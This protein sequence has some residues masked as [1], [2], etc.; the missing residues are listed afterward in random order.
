MLHLLLPYLQDPELLRHLTHAQL[1]IRQSLF[2]FRLG[3]H[4][5][6]YCIC[7]VFCAIFSHVRHICKPIGF[8]IGI[9][10]RCFSIM[11]KCYFLQI[12]LC[13]S[14]CDRFNPVKIFRL[15]LNIAETCSIDNLELC[16]VFQNNFV[17]I[18]IHF[19]V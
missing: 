2:H 16:F 14:V 17:H 9:L 10:A 1:S 6:G 4:I 3:S 11:C 15:N 18:F 8:Q 5:N 13:E 7:T 12:V 19:Y